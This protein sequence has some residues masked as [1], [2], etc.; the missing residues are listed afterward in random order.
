MSATFL[1]DDEIAELTG[2]KIKS[3][4]IE[5]LRKMGLPFFVNAIG[6][7]VVTRSVIDK[8]ANTPAAPAEKKRWVPNV[9]RGK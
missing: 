4:Q 2:R 3:K 6:R 1:N 5:A 7:A 9:L 8:G